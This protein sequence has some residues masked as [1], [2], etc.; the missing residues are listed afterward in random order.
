MKLKS[1]NERGKND[2][3]INE[4]N[5]K[6]GCIYKTRERKKLNYNEGKVCSAKQKNRV[7]ISKR[8]S[9]SE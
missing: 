4:N 9:F 3:K 8:S 7:Q 2:A 6:H 1:D 5:D